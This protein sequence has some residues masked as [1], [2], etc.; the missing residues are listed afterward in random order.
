MMLLFDRLYLK[1]MGDIYIVN[2][3]NYLIGRY[4]YKMILLKRLYIHENST[5]MPLWLIQPQY[6]QY[7]YFKNTFGF[8][9][10]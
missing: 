1:Y 7:E 9:N 5:D 10:L 6:Y 4:I 3:N 2:L 8:Y